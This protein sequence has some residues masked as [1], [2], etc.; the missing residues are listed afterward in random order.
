M[1]L[2]TLELSLCPKCRGKL[3]IEKS[4]DGVYVHCSTCGL[5]KPLF[6]DDTPLHF[7][8]KDHLRHKGRTDSADQS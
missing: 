6:R 2:L 1:K 4:L 8:P 5:D 7:I 3:T